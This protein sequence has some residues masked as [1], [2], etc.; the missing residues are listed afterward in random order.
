MKKKIKDCT[1]E[2][3]LRYCNDKN[4][5]FCDGCPLHQLNEYY[6]IDCLVYPPCELKLKILNEEIEILDE[7]VGNSDKLE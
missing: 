7:P 5:T 1:I 3:F 2:E 4:C 6:D